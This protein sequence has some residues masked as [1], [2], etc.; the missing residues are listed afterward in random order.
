MKLRLQKLQNKDKQAWKTKA[1][2]SEIWDG[3]KKVLYYQ[4]LAYISRIIWTS[5]INKYY[6]YQ[7]IDFFG[8]NKT[9]KLIAYIYY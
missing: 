6:F 7:L 2:H 3:I 9:K 8:I 5:F 4:S 1:K